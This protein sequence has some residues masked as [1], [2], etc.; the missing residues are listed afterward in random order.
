L[1]FSPIDCSVALVISLKVT[2]S[3]I[4]IDPL[5]SNFL[6]LQAVEAVD[7]SAALQAQQSPLHLANDPVLGIWP[8]DTP[9]ETTA[10]VLKD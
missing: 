5:I 2:D 9:V 1:K 10:P 6:V 7:S 3:W 4:E 8:V